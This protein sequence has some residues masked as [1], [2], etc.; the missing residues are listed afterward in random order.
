[1][2]KLR[3]KTSGCFRSEQ[4]AANFRRIRSYLSSVRK[5]GENLSLKLFR[6]P[7]RIG[8]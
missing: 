5:Q 2:V 8:R 7:A 1:M 4:G 3:Q 6:E